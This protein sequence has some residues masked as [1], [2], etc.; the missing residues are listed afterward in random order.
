VQG[1]W[2]VRSAFRRALEVLRDEGFRALWF[3]VLGETVYRR[4]TLFELSLES[5]PRIREPAVGLAFGFID[6]GDEALQALLPGLTR[7]EI[8][9][10]LTRGDRCF[11][12]WDEGRI[13]S[14]RWIAADR[15]WVEYLDRDMELQSDEVYLYETYTAPDYRGL[16]VSG[17]AGTRLARFLAAEG[18]RR[19]V[20]GVVPENHAA[21]RTAAK[22]GYREV[23]RMGYM[24]LGP[25]RHDFTRWRT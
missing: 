1:R 3:K 13:V 6:P 11:V 4:L 20:G 16:T 23:G 15:A 10:R 21:L 19:I 5:P 2:T 7:A 17:A 24:R 12:A 22:T 25:W 18:Y 9:R 14:A 8:D